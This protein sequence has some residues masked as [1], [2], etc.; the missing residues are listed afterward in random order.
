MGMRATDVM[1]IQPPVPSLASS[2]LG[3]EK[4]CEFHV[5]PAAGSCRGQSSCPRHAVRL[6]GR[7]LPH[8]ASVHRKSQKGTRARIL[9][10]A[11]P[12]AQAN[13]RALTNLLR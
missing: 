9:F 10:A 4:S 1:C 3:K 13:P 5:G 12:N 8:L 6:T 7:S 11:D 2:S